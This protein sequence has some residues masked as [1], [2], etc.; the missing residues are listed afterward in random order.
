M[1][2][3]S[4]CSQ[5]FTRKELQS[6]LSS[7]L[8]S[9]D[10]GKVKKLSDEQFKALYHFLNGRDT[11]ACLPTGHGKTLICQIA[12]LVARTGKVNFLPSNPLVVVVSPLNALISDQLDSCRRLKLKAL[13][14]EQELF[15][16]DDKVRELDEAEVVFCSPETLE[17]IR[18]K[19]FL[20]RMEDRL[21]GIVVDES[22]CV[23]SW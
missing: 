3:S 16:N 7:V 22:H 9:F 19:Q 18:S 20:L 14:M 8:E 2:F 23:V 12:V 11:F 17:N 10:N 13:K 1:A 21:I 5:E 15:N 4:A 6:L